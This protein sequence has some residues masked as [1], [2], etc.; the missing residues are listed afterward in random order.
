MPSRPGRARGL[1]AD[2]G[3]RLSCD[4]R[5]PTRRG[6][7]G[8]SDIDAHSGLPGRQS[9]RPARRFLAAA[10]SPGPHV[11]RV[12]ALTR[13]RQ[14]LSCRG[15]RSAG[16]VLV[17]SSGRLAPRMEPLSAARGCMR[18]PMTCCASRSGRAGSSS[19]RSEVT[20]QRSVCSAMSPGRCLRRKACP[21]RRSS[22]RWGRLLLERGR[23]GKA[24]SI[25]GEAASR[26]GG[27]RTTGSWDGAGVAGGCEDRRGATDGGR[28]AVCR[29]R[30]SLV[31]RSARRHRADACSGRILLWQGR[32]SSR[33]VRLSSRS[34]Q[35]K[36]VRGL[37]TTAR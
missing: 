2:R 28:I 5:S 32:V 1:G 31:R 7:A 37:E 8:A 21:L 18:F 34:I 35:S 27:R 22:S 4:L 17:T 30:C 24:D 16:P 33:D 19:S 29:R 12:V 9:N 26:P 36:S 11:F 25:F 10:A 14:R 6:A 15:R 20:R 3:G 23:G 13:A